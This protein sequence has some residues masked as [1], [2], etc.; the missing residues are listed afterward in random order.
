M[1]YD[2]SSK[3]LIFSKPLQIRLVK[4]DGI[5]RIYDRTRYLT[6]FDNEKYDVIYEIIRYLISIKISIIY[7]FLYFV[8]MKVNSYDS[9]PTEKR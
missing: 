9:L 5:I 7:F 3:T 4:T 1:I 8:K 6:L 2:I